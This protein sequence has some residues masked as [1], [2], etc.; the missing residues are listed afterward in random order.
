MK[1]ALREMF[2]SQPVVFQCPHVTILYAS[3]RGCW[4][5]LSSPPLVGKG[6]TNG[7]SG[8]LTLGTG[9]A[10]SGEGGHVELCVGEGLTGAGGNITIN[11]GGTN[12]PDSPG[13]SVKLLAG[14]GMAGGGGQVILRSG[15]AS[16]SSDGDSGGDLELVA[17]S[18][19][20]G[21]EGEG[22]SISILSGPSTEG[23]AGQISLKSADD[24][25]TTGKITLAS[26]PVSYTHLRAHET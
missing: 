26:G 15:N 4:H 16:D 19:F 11:A 24:S 13:G 14:G 9:L 12:G 21:T 20:G 8:N 3:T 17:G 6:G 18:A 23:T 2:L 7:L 25:S 10:S 22:G 1:V 5:L